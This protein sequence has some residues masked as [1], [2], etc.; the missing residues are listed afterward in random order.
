MYIVYAIRYILHAISCILRLTAI[1]DH[2]RG[3]NFKYL[4]FFIFRFKVCVPNYR[5]VC[6]FHTFYTRLAALLYCN[7]SSKRLSL[8]KFKHFFDKVK[9]SVP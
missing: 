5:F 7:S 6:R 3:Y 4:P 2:S 9:I 1:K 8:C